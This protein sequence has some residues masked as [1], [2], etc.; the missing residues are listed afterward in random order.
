M[1]SQ[2]VN[3]SAPS[4]FDRTYFAKRVAQGRALMAS[5]GL[6]AILAFSAPRGLAAATR[7]SGNLGWFAGF[8][9]IWAPSLLLL[10]AEKAVIVAPGKN[11]GRLFSTRVGN[12]FEIQVA[13]PEG[14]MARAVDLLGG[15]QKVGTAGTDELP[16]RFAGTLAESLPEARPIDGALQALR[17]QREPIE[18]DLHRRASAISDAMIECAF[19]YAASTDARPARL[20]A[21]V[22]HEG[23]WLGADISRLWLSTGPNPPVTFFEMFEL[24]P[25]IERGD[26][27]QLGTMVS[28]EGYFAQ[29]LRIGSLGRPRPELTDMVGRIEA[30]QDDAL[31]LIRPGEPVHGLVDLIEARI[32]A[33]CPYSRETDPFR[34]QS[35]HGL[36]LD[37]SEPGVATALSPTRDRSADR[38][39]PLFQPGMV[40]EIHPNFSLPGLGHVC[41]G[42]VALV[43]E[44]G[45]EW[46]TRFPRGVFEIA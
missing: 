46:L 5:L 7:T 16:P 32:D 36:G 4:P 6:E 24:P 41:A 44:T 43:T 21:E 33:I 19:A 3:A 8:S 23:R 10:T 18:V 9:P 28:C 30:I 2:P 22:E 14:I 15:V 25:S 34:F 1:P 27:V 26:R 17:L 13:G 37:Y 40:F 35:C 39:G 45:A 31:S 20:M 38:G 11:E 29:G 12:A 42:D